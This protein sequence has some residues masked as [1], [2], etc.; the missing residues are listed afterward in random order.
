MPNK[1]ILTLAGISLAALVVGT[2]T[3]Y[4]SEVSE[5]FTNCPMNG[6][7]QRKMRM[8]TEDRDSKREEHLSEAVQNGVITQEQ[9][10]L[11]DA[12]HAEMSAE[13]E[14]YREEMKANREN[15]RAEHEAWAAENG[16]DLDVLRDGMG[17]KHNR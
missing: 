9:K 8:S 1:T 7:G 11:L 2:G 10:D 15:N 13:R 6:E 3:T 12:K 5:D 17:P 14:A 4:A 16:I